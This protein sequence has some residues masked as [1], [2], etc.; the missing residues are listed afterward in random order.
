MPMQG[1]LLR[2]AVPGQWWLRIELALA[3]FMG[4]AATVTAAAITAGS[5]TG[6]GAA[7]AGLARASMVAVPIGVGLYAWH[8]RPADPFGRLLV[9]AGFGCFLTTLAESSDELLYSI[10]RVAAWVVEIGLVWLILAF[11]SGRLTTRVDRLLLWAAVALLAVLYLPTAL[12]AESFPVPTPY[13]SCEANCPGNA[14][15]IGT[16]PGFYDSTVVP[17]REALTALIFL[18]VTARL[19]QRVRGATPLMRLTLSPVLAVAA[20]RLS[21]VAL[22]V[23]VR[24]VSPGS[25]VLD[26]L[27]WAIALAIP[28]VAV[29][30]LLGLFQRRLYAADALQR[31]GATARGSLG[32]E[33]LRGVVA[34]AVGDPTLQ[35]VYR[36]NGPRGHWIDADGEAVEPPDPE[37]GQCLTEVH[38]GRRL[39]AGVVHDDALRDQVDFVQAVASYAL[40]ALENQRLAAKVKSSLLEVRES[41]RRI[42]ASG[43]RERRRIERDLHDGAQQRLV[44]LGI[45]LELTEELIKRDPARGI[46]KLHALGTEVSKTLEEIQGLARGV[47]P[48]LLADLGLAEALRAAARRLPT[49]VM[50][51]QDGIGRYPAGV[52]NAAYFCCLEAMQNASKH[53]P[54]AASITIALRQGDGLEFEV[55]DDGAGFDLADVT[56]GAGFANMQDRLAAVGGV[57]DIRSVPGAGTVVAGR[58]PV[59]AS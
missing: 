18:G 36:A 33:D 7:L 3:G 52:E 17:L 26:G 20:A 51:E 2:R 45:Q 10:G 11:P 16:E 1:R 6:E 41:R 35:I 23:I 32:R 25:P 46:E 14:F 57:V 39:V 22:T 31:L 38:D 8:H 4:L 50:V 15:I 48:A 12:I 24:R 28:A 37:S 19:A 54:D 30:F 9:A 13:T 43:D 53:A 47:Y 58:I 59:T 56:A 55:R 5:V 42:L 27:V 34:G 29:A 44:A 40:V 21:L 49:P